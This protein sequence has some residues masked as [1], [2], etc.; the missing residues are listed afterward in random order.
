MSM[1][2]P[3]TPP[4]QDAGEVEVPAADPGTGAP[5]TAEGTGPQG[6]DQASADAPSAEEGPL[7]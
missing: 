6:E 4:T 3:F 2:T 7:A 5:P 1:S